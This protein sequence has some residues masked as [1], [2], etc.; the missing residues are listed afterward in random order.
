MTR[1]QQAFMD[2]EQEARELFVRDW[3]L[4]EYPAD[5]LGEEINESITFMDLFHVLDRYQDV[6]EFLGA[7]DSVIRER[8]FT[9]LAEIMEVD[10]SYI[11]DQWLLGA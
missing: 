3:Y 5:H 11:Y 7:V 1:E 8:V 6:Y 2:R 4:L 10:Y 9:K